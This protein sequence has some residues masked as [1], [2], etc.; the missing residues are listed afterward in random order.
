MTHSCTFV[1][2]WDCFLFLLFLATPF[3]FPRHKAFIYYDTNAHYF[4]L[5][6]SVLL[7]LCAHG[8]REN[9]DIHGHSLIVLVIPAEMTEFYGSTD[10]V[11][12]KLFG[13][14]LVLNEY[15]L[16]VFHLNFRSNANANTWCTWWQI[17]HDNSTEIFLDCLLKINE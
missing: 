6:T 8:G 10:I 12:I 13:N 11:C 7:I 2:S 5:S 1:N 4:K 9:W 14:E 15:D 17:R 16:I 3:S